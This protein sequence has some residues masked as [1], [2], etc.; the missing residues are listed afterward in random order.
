M[1]RWTWY[2]AHNWKTPYPGDS[3]IYAPAEVPGGTIPSGDHD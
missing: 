1:N 3:K 2:Q